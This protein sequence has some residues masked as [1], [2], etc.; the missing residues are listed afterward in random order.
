MS[1]IPLGILAAAGAG[2]EVTGFELIETQTLS[3][4]A[5]SITFSNLDSYSNT[6]YGLQINWTV[7]GIHSS[8]DGL[9]V[10]INNDSGN[11]YYWHG[12]RNQ[13][14]TLEAYGAGPQNSMEM[15]AIP[16]S[17]E[18]SSVFASGIINIYDAFDPTKNTVLYGRAGLFAS[19]IT[20]IRK[21]SGIWQ[22][23]N[24]LSSI[25]FTG[26]FNAIAANSEIS[27]YGLVG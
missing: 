19:N 25:T 3:S 18:P 23:T 24:T 13:N 12:F 1:P 21:H 16:Q 4:S 26:L 15:G 11:N 6:F 14:N 7:R 27:I 22:N 2:G 9:R 20:Y 10:R 8:T 17:S 5:S